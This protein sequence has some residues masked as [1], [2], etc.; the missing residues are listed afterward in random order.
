MD[1]ASHR[2][3]ES[4]LKL[5]KPTAAFR[6]RAWLLFQSDQ[7][8]LERGS[9]MLLARR[10]RDEFAYA[11]EFGLAWPLVLPCSP[12]PPSPSALEG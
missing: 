10:S 6:R 2:E 8:E 1:A 12:V 3:T 5:P 9:S 7:D 11:A 4:R